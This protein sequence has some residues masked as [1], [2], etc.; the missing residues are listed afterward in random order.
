MVLGRELKT[1]QNVKKIQRLLGWPQ[2]SRPA[3]CAECLHV[4]GWELGGGQSKG[5]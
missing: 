4:G 1:P 3:D 2:V 5:Y